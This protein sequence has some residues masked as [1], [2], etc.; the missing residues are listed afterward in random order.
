MTSYKK[1]RE[2]ML[3]YLSPKSSRKCKKKLM[4][5]KILPFCFGCTDNQ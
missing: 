3:R 5:C 4:S 1:M 2:Y